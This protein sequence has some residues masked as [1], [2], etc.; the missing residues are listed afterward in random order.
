MWRNFAKYPRF[1]KSNF[2]TQ[3]LLMG[4][5]KKGLCDLYTQI[6]AICLSSCFWFIYVY[7]FFFRCPFL[8]AVSLRSGR[9][10]CYL[11]LCTI[12]WILCFNFSNFKCSLV[13]VCYSFSLICFSLLSLGVQISTQHSYFCTLFSIWWLVFINLYSFHFIYF[14]FTFFN[15]LHHFTDT[16][17]FPFHF[18]FA[19]SLFFPYHS[20]E[21]TLFKI[22]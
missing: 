22:H 7:C 18:T 3:N 21:F 11:P 9:S 5:I 2:W 19:F 1:Q 10:F 16:H 4:Y 6:P 15:F 14:N 12:L 13:Y 8:S 17:R 20:E